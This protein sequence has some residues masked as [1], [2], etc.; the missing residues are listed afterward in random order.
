MLSVHLH[1]LLVLRVVFAVP[2]YRG[3]CSF[4]DLFHLCFFLLVEVS[5]GVPAPGDHNQI[6]QQHEACKLTHWMPQLNHQV[7]RGVA[8]ITFANS[9][10]AKKA[11]S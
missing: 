2:G 5:L 10:H 3:T 4:F 8:V 1:V 6:P 11:Q 7:E 9:A